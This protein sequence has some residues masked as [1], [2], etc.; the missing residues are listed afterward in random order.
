ME[1]E[2]E[3]KEMPK[4]EVIPTVYYNVDYDIFHIP[5]VNNVQVK[6]KLE[7]ISGTEWLGD[8]KEFLN[9]YIF[10]SKPLILCENNYNSGHDLNVFYEKL[11]VVLREHGFSMLEEGAT[12][13][14]YERK[15]VKGNMNLFVIQ[16]TD[17]ITLKMIKGT[18]V[19]R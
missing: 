5:V 4:K 1:E 3:K 16:G 8:S 15:F 11:R 12:D 10:I 7:V 14:G 2:L 6:N 13:K 9:Q 19:D 18:F 17:N